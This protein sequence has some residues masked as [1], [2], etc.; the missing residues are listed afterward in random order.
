VVEMRGSIQKDC[1]G[2]QTTTV[3]QFPK[4]S[5]RKQREGFY[6][7]ESMSH[8]AK[9]PTYL[10]QA[11]I[12][13]YTKAGEL[14]LDPMT[15]IGTT[16]IEAV[17]LGRN[18]IGVEYEK[19]FVDMANK[20]LRITKEKLGSS[21]GT[22]VIIKGD[23]R[24][25]SKTLSKHNFDSIIFSPPFA[26]TLAGSSKDDLKKY[27]HGSAGKDYGDRDD[28][29]QIGNLKYS[30]ID[31]IIFS[32]PY[33][34]VVCNQANNNS[35]LCRR[36]FGYMVPYSE[37][38]K[39]GALPDEINIGMQKG[40]TYLAEML[41]VYEECYKVLKPGSFMILVVKNFRRKGEEINLMA[42]TIQLCKAAGFKYFQTCIRVLNEASFWQINNVRKT[43]HL[44]LNLIEYVLVFR[45]Y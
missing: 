23:A 5:P 2:K 28:K 25:L 4:V 39:K 34:E 32:P 20:N 16:I 21:A 13:S 15:G 31:T 41:K 27:K 12:S 7:E 29:N 45:K 40:A 18:A 43:P 26:D 22:G 42:N 17:K 37:K 36:K 8:P 9:M 44:M 30:P 35:E 14:I 19:N 24:E 11:I 1:A 33:E 38:T 10:A 3:W 6:C